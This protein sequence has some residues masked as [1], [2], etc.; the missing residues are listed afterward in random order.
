MLNQKAT[1]IYD[2]IVDRISQDFSPTVR[3]ICRDLNIKSTSTVH[4]YL[5]QL[6]EAGLI[7]KDDN[8]NR[9]I[10]LAQQSGVTRVPILGAVAAGNPITAIE[11]IEGYLPFDGAG[12]QGGDLFALRIAGDS[13]IECGI[14]D[15]DLVIVKKTPTAVN[16]EIVV[17]LVE[18]E[19]TVKRFYKE[20]GYY[21]LQPENAD[22]QPIIVPEVTIL[23]KVVA[24]VRY[25]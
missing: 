25:F 19:A 21:R 16:G 23:G 13:M 5:A 22:Y 9:S 24:S 1:A 14:F 20:Q 18:E 2:Y 8:T 10:R 7:I 17:A 11:E 15:S 12:F 4:R 3:E 6:C